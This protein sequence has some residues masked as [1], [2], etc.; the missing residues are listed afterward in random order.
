MHS[1]ASN[2][3]HVLMVEGGNCLR[4]PVIDYDV[5][6]AVHNMLQLEESKGAIYEL[7]GPHNYTLKELMEYIANVLNHRP[8]FIP[9]TYDECMKI[10]YAPNAFFEV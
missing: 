6:L 7:G 9:M 8:V 4:Q 2:N 3:G 5:C 1:W 10:V